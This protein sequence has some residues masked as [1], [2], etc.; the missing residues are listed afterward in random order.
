[1]ME[2]NVFLHIGYPKTGTSALQ[3][4]L[5]SHDSQLKENGFLYPEF[6]EEPQGRFAE[7]FYAHH[8]ASP[9]T[10]SYF[11]YPH[12]YQYYLESLLEAAQ[13]TPCKNIIISSENFLYDPPSIFEKFKSSFHCYVVV[14]LR[15]IFSHI[16][17]ITKESLR[18]GENQERYED[19]LN[20]S[21]QTYMGNIKEYIRYFSKENVI[22]RCYDKVTNIERDFFDAVAQKTEV[23]SDIYTYIS[24]NKVVNKSLCDAAS[25]FLYHISCLPIHH[26]RFYELSKDLEKI[27]IADFQSCFI[28]PNIMRDEGTLDDIICLQS[29]LLEDYG[30]Y[31]YSWSQYDKYN[32]LMGKDITNDMAYFIYNS[33][34]PETRDILNPYLCFEEGKPLLPMI[35]TL[36][37]QI[38]KIILALRAVFDSNSQDINIYKNNYD[39]LMHIYTE[40]VRENESMKETN[41]LMSE[42]IAES[43]NRNSILAQENDGLTIRCNELSQKV[44]TYESY[45]IIKFYN[46]IKKRRQKLRR[47]G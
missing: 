19:R 28:L 43:K 1:M 42:E 31:E 39:N 45:R 15:N 46:S 16:N 3:F 40:V 11:G 7:H 13:R 18:S 9:S 2:K 4:S 10:N 47:K 25:R 29:L 20:Y 14:Y 36:D 5:R 38:K 27:E 17:S 34:C 37:P 8:Y 33:L 44:H 12:D 41:R 6:I 30:W 24:T 35:G 21:A 23:N 22:F 26:N 32:A